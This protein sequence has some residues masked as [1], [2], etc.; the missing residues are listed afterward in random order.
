MRQRPRRS[1]SSQMAD[2]RAR[3]RATRRR[4]TALVAGLVLAAPFV[5]VVVGAPGALTVAGATS[6]S[7]AAVPA[8]AHFRLA[9]IKAATPFVVAAITLTMAPA[10]DG[11]SVV[12]TLRGNP[13]GDPT[14]PDHVLS[15]ANSALAPCSQKTLGTPTEVTRGT[16]T[17]DLCAA[18][19]PAGYVSVHDLTAMALTAGGTPVQVVPTPRTQGATSSSSGTPPGSST[20]G[21]TGSTG[22]T[23]NPP[24]TGSR[25]PGGS[26]PPSHQSGARTG[27]GPPG[28]AGGSLGSVA[29]GARSSSSGSS[30]HQGHHH[31][32]RSSSST[33]ATH[34]HRLL[35]GAVAF[36]FWP[37]LFAF[38]LLGLLLLF[39]FL[40][41]RRRHHDEEAAST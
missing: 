13:S 28:N 17:L 15:T 25:T 4:A 27:T 37:L 14:R 12:L 26:T 31:R 30:A 36:D 9:R 24:G 39:L 40:L 3:S 41:W 22:T 23:G 6:G 8:H 16:I 1:N 29:I 2:G 19:G 32:H 21:T 10:C 35:A 38:L 18:G 20:T 7:C 34:H 33:R 5:V 11:A